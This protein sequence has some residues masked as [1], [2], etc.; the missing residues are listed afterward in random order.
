MSEMS[1][2]RKEDLS[3]YSY[4]KE[5]V[6][7]N[8][9]EFDS[10]AQLAIMPDLCSYDSYVYE[11]VTSVIPSP[12]ARGRGLVYFDTVFSGTSCDLYTDLVGLNG[13]GKSALGVPE[14]SDIVTIYENTATVSG[15][16][17]TVV[18]GTEYM[19]D[20]IDGRIITERKLVNPTISY[21][22]HYVSIVDEWA[23]I[24]AA[25]PPVIVVD[26]Y[27]TDKAGYQLGGGKKS[28]RKVDIHIFASDPAERNDLVEAIYNGVYLKSCKLLDFKTGTVLD[29]DGTF[30]GRRDL[31]ERYPGYDFSAELQEYQDNNKL[32]YLFDR[33][34]V[35]NVSRLYFDNVT[36]RHVNLP[37]IMTRGKDEA[38]LSDL[39]A[40]RAKV[41]FDLYCYD[42][43][44][45]SI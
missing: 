26:M 10:G 23:A 6:L 21:Y 36:S 4:I 44:S 3:L 15:I 8:F 11:I 30:Y 1:I 29:Y 45:I 31:E 17:T 32:T 42:D 2:L 40:Y 5:S 37:L 24:Q 28:T 39:N 20:Y 25:D 19:I 14:Q 38:M 34:I 18:S 16:V 9:I 22:W 12:T 7:R 33:A 41:S 35:E 13:D 27:G 43:R